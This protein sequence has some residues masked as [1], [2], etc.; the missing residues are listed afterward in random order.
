MRFPDGFFAKMQPK[1]EE[2]F[3]AMRELEAGGIA[4]PDE[5][6]MVGHYWLRDAALAPNDELRADVEQT[7]ARILKFAS[8]VHV[9]R[10]AAPSGRPFEH[11]L[12][13]G[14]GGSA[15]GPQFIADALRSNHDLMDIFF[16]DNTDPDGFDRVFDRIGAGLDHTLVV[17]I[18]KSGGTKETRNGMLEAKARFEK[19]GLD[20]GKQAVAVTGE[21]SELDKYA[22]SNALAGAFPDV[23]LDWRPYL[24]DERGRPAAG[25]F[26]GT[27]RGEFPPGCGGDGRADASA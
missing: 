26:A 2:A 16:F 13:I 3:A 18:S 27:R 23:R 21:G 8:D 7:K 10:I 20:F 17:V 14:I 19:A 6:R 15:L 1:A 12:L 24:R 11:V 9:A 5:N 22:E 25:G 4:N